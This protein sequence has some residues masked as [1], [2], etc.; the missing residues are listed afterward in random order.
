MASMDLGKEEVVRWIKRHFKQGATCL[1]V[2]PCDGK[3]ADILGDYLTMDAVEIFEP[4][5]VNHRLDEKYRYVWIGDI[6]QCTYEWYDL[7]IFGDVIEHMT[8]EQAQHTLEYAKDR[9]DD[10]IVAVP[11]MFDQDEQ[12][13]NPY[14]KHIQNDL[15]PQRFNSRYPGFRMIFRPQWNYAYYT[16]DKGGEKIGST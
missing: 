13:G 6:S 5:V 10:M 9:C 1:D 3:W 11:F 12:Y 2:G 4:N 7:I 15:T 16:K 8:V 14:E